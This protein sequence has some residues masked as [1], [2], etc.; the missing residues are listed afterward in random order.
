MCRGPWGC[1]ASHPIEHPI[2]W[3]VFADRQALARLQHHRDDLVRLNVIVGDRLVE[4]RLVGGNHDLS[5][6]SFVCHRVSPIP[7]RE[8]QTR[9]MRSRFITLDHAATKSF[10]NFSFES[11]QA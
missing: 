9:S 3:A 11:A 5:N 6:L 2:L 4:R 1:A 10:T 7:F 8:G